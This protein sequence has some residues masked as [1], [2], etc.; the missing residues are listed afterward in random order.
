VDGKHA[1][2]EEMIEVGIKA[3][4]RES[5]FYGPPDVDGREVVVAIFEAMI[6]LYD[7]KSVLAS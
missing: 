1:I 5:G 7:A 4:G 6:S 3:W 2:T